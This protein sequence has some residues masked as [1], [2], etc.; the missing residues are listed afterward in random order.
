MINLSIADLMMGNAELFLEAKLNFFTNTFQ[1]SI[2][3]SLRWLIWKRGECT[4][5]MPLIGSTVCRLHG[6]SFAFSFPFFSFHY[7]YRLWNYRL[8]HC[9][10][11]TIVDIHVD[12]D[13]TG[14]MV[15]NH[16]C[17]STE[18]K[19]EAK[20]L[21]ESDDWPMGICNLY[22]NVATVW[23]QFVL[24]NQHL[25]TYGT[26]NTGWQHLSLFSAGH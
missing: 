2:C 10:C 25:L 11:S 24:E 26:Q 19:I 14:T 12:C 22:G 8:H 23:N 21:G 7:R 4:S 15:C 16:F 13:H 18:S 5:I 20:P 3:S 9:V 1:E 17:H 6:E